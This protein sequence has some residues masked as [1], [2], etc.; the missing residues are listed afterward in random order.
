M[1]LCKLNF[2][3]LLIFMSSCWTARLPSSSLSLSSLFVNEFLD[4]ENAALDDQSLSFLKSFLIQAGGLRDS[5]EVVVILPKLLKH[6][7]GVSLGNPGVFEPNFW[8]KSGG[9]AN[10]SNAVELL[11]PDGDLFQILLSHE[12]F[13]GGGCSLIPRI[14][15]PFHFFG[16]AEL[17]LNLP[18]FFSSRIASQ[19][20]GNL[21]FLT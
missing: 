13:S 14:S 1:N 10:F 18:F 8:M 15:V 4:S 7:L 6:A 16:A 21:R 3:S 12:L 5:R 19:N 11:Q 17:K 2:K 20:D 9:S